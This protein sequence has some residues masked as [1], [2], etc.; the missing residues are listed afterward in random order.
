VCVCVCVCV[1]VRYISNDFTWCIGGNPLHLPKPKLV[2]AAVLHLRM[3]NERQT[4]RSVTNGLV[5]GQKIEFSPSQT[6]SGLWL[7]KLPNFDQFI[8]LRVEHW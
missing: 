3:P 1:C 6:E 7:I 2:R 4:L 8:A 5:R